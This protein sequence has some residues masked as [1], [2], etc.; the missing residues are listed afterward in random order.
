MAR[1]SPWPTL[2]GAAALVA[3]PVLATA[4]TS[5]SSTQTPQTP[6][7]QQQPTET[8]NASTPDEHLSAAKQTLNSIPRAAV[9]G[10][11]A[12]KM[13]DVR[14]HFAALEKSYSAKASGSA[15]GSAARSTKSAKS[16]SW[17]THLM[18]LDRAL[19]DLLGSSTGAAPEATGTSGAAAVDSDVRVKLEEFRTHI[20][21]FAAAASGTSASGSMSSPAASAPSSSS[22]SSAGAPTSTTPS[23]PAQ[24]AQSTP[25]QSS[26]QPQTPP[27][28][29]SSTSA[30]GSQTTGTAAGSTTATA[31]ADTSAA[32]EHLTQARQSLADL[33]AM[34]QAQQLQGETRNKVSQLISQFN[35][36]ITTQGDWR[37]AY[38]EVNTTLTALLSASASASGSTSS[39]TSGAVGTS[40]TAA[41][42]GSATLDP[43][44]RSKLEEFRTRLEAFHTAA[45][46][47][48]EGSAGS[49]GS[50]SST[51]S[52]PAG[53]TSTGSTSSA[54]APAS[55][56]AETHIAAIERILDEA[57]GS[58]ASGSAPTGTSGTPAGGTTGSASAG[59]TG[60]VTL[61]RAKLEQIRT[62]LQQ[63][64]QAIRK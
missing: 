16:G 45:G 32:R 41:A 5:G 14:R 59:A 25:S 23:E 17:N 12:A 51:G 60:T 9:T 13:N 48:A 50:M 53:S 22:T 18:A 33:T 34:P 29:T 40:G 61:D 20:T 47:A 30:A 62:H 7:T 56:D 64:R 44:L 26:S 19:S 6:T 38:N 10:R 1:T 46:G 49:T 15:T 11:N 31:Q 37:S 43:A 55:G 54:P 58:S 8:A 39:S 27:S 57:S 28:S 35:Q 21:Q 63:L 42:T 52:S 36:L 4:Q 24:T 3:L 2:V